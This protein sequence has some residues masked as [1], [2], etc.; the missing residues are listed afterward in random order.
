[1]KH[2][3]NK[4]ALPAPLIGEEDVKRLQ[5]EGWRFSDGGV[6]TANCYC[7]WGA[8]G[9]ELQV[10]CLADPDQYPWAWSKVPEGVA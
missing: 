7:V 6:R 5:G 1:M 10:F 9:D 2:G 4:Q 8:K 3:S